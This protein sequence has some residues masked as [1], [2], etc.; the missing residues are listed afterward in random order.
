MYARIYRYLSRGRYSHFTKKNCALIKTEENLEEE[1]RF[2][3][4]VLKIGI[5]PELFIFISFMEF[6]INSLSGIYGLITQK[7]S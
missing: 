2:I 6:H 4:L 1:K 7:T 5:S 3:I